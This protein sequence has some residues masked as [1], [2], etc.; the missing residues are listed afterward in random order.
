MQELAERDHADEDQPDDEHRRDDFLALLGG[1][2]DGERDHGAMLTDQRAMGLERRF[3]VTAPGGAGGRACAEGCRRRGPNLAVARQ[4]IRPQLGAVRDQRGQVGDG[5]DRPGLGDADETVRVEVVAEQERG[6]VVG[7]REQARAA[8]V[9]QVALVDRLQPQR[10][11]LL[12]E[13]R[14]DRLGLALAGRAQGVRPERALGRRLLRDRPP[15]IDRYSQPA[16]S[17]VQ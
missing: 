5:L 3:G 7:R 4:A 14:E 11:P 6:V 1:R 10:V 12:A 2:L 9:E 16:S 17:F 8:V 15:E 13:R